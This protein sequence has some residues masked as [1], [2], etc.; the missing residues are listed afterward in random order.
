MNAIPDG[1][2]N[3]AT[4]Q[5]IRAEIVKVNKAMTAALVT[6]ADAGEGLAREVTGVPRE[7]LELLSKAGPGQLAAMSAVGFP[8]WSFR[9][10]SPEL[11]NELLTG[12]NHP[13][14]IT[15]SQ[16]VRTEIRKTNTALMAALLAAAHVESSI[17]PAI[18][19]V[20]GATLAILAKAKPVQLETLCSG[21]VRLWEYRFATVELTRALIA[22]ET[23]SIG[24]THCFL[25]GLAQLPRTKGRGS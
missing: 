7:T 24:I 9:F 17:S 16:L 15:L 11:A 25:S 20:P 1:F 6:A 14:A 5:L 19:C 18:V 13:P 12:R 8:L 22:G 3:I 23:G 4:S 2:V 21:G 10:P